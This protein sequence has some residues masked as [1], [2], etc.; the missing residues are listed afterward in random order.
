MLRFGFKEFNK[1]RAVNKRYCLERYVCVKHVKHSHKRSHTHISTCSHKNT[2]V[3]AMNCFIWFRFGFGLVLV[4]L[5][6][7]YLTRNKLVEHNFAYFLK[8]YYMN[9][10]S[11][12]TT[13]SKFVHKTTL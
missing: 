13:W 7:P 8:N 5:I 12:K 9:G 10:K 11:D 1:Q 2:R 4:V 6:S 3:H